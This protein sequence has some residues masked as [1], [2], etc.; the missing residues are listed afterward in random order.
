MDSPYASDSDVS[1]DSELT[2]LS[3]IV[4]SG[5]RHASQK[6][7]GD[8]GV[9]KNGT[10]STPEDME[11]VPLNKDESA[12]DEDDWVMP[13]EEELAAAGA[14]IST[15]S[16]YPVD[17][18]DS[19]DFRFDDVE[20]MT[21]FFYDGPEEDAGEQPS[22]LLSGYDIFIGPYP[23]ERPYTYE[24]LH[25]RKAKAIAFANKIPGIQTLRETLSVTADVAQTNIARSYKDIA[26]RVVSTAQGTCEAVV[27]A[28]QVGGFLVGGALNAGQNVA[29]S[30]QESWPGWPLPFNRGVLGII[31]EYFLEGFQSLPPTDS[32]IRPRGRR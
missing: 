19:H 8:D 23:H 17:E 14:S 27:I 15:Q 11:D 10:K 9:S 3:E 32:I 25:P 12:E 26:G 13:D 22:K 16:E 1:S 21:I 4:A 30:V 24:E 18:S 2:N 29:V 20:M 7:F 31:G 6:R 28:G 5:S